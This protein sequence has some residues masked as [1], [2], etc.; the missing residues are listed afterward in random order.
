MQ[1]RRDDDDDVSTSHPF[2]ITTNTRIRDDGYRILE[3]FL[4]QTMCVCFVYGYF[5]WIIFKQWLYLSYTSPFNWRYQ[6]RF[7]LAW[8]NIGCAHFSLISN[9]KNWH[10]VHTENANF[11]IKFLNNKNIFQ[12]LLKFMREKNS[13]HRWHCS[14]MWSNNNKLILRWDETWW[15]DFCGWK[16]NRRQKYSLH[17]IE[18]FFIQLK[19]YATNLIKSHLIMQ[20]PN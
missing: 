5:Q 9:K 18:E 11:S 17:S 3:S 13:N 1:N 4:R 2:R 7:T 19:N 20:I 10:K 8:N 16:G 14:Q 6:Y 12:F 15:K